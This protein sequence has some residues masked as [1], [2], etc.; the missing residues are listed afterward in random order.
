LAFD[1]AA[2]LAIGDWAYALVT[3]PASMWSP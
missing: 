2:T 3:D 1:L